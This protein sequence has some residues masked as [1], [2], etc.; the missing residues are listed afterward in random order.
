MLPVRCSARSWKRTRHFIMT[1]HYFAQSRS[2][3][4]RTRTQNVDCKPANSSKS[5]VSIK[6]EKVDPVSSSAVV[7]LEEEEAN[8][9]GNIYVL[10]KNTPENTAHVLQYCYCASSVLGSRLKL[11]CSLAR[12][13]T[14]RHP[15]LRFNPC[16]STFCLANLQ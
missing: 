2:V 7:K 8:I 9:S 11:L 10:R 15:S 1:S 3:V 12:R 16:S 14:M 6:S 5:K 4:T 13:D